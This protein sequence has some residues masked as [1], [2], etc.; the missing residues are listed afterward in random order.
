M[1]WR[2]SREK[3]RIWMCCRLRRGEQRS[4]LFEI[5][6]QGGALHNRRKAYLDHLGVTKVPEDYEDRL[7]ECFLPY[8]RLRLRICALNPY[9]LALFKLER[10]IQRDRDGVRH[11]ERTIPLDVENLLVGN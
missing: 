10:N 5:G 3:R 11:L 2:D 4:R 7:A 1:I 8:E 6:K 9:D